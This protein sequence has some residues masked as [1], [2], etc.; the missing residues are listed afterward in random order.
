MLLNLQEINTQLP[1]WLLLLLPHVLC[2]HL[3]IEDERCCAI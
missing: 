2:A 3:L 1:V